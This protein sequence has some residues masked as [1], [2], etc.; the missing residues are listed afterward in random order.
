MGVWSSCCNASSSGAG[1]SAT[2]DPFADGS[3][4]HVLFFF[5]QLAHCGL[6]SSHLTWR[7]RHVRLIQHVRVRIHILADHCTGLIPSC[8][9]TQTTGP[10]LCRRR[11]DSCGG[12]YVGGVDAD[13]LE[14]AYEKTKRDAVIRGQARFR[15]ELNKSPRDEISADPMTV[16]PIKPLAHR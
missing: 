7:L 14:K 8:S 10:G 5:A 6:R 9:Y 16:Q 3:Y 11:W 12:H 4:S 2:S 13:K 15:V 1:E